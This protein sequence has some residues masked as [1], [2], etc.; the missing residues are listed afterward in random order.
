[1]LQPILDKT[2]CPQYTIRLDVT[3]FQASSA[4]QALLRKWDRFLAG[5]AAQRWRM[6]LPLAPGASATSANVHA[7]TAHHSDDVTGWREPL[8]CQLDTA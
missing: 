7:I 3:Q 2:C 1:M 8:L 4:Q 6:W 5:G